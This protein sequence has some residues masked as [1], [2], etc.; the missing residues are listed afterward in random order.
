LYSWLFRRLMTRSPSC[1]SKLSGMS[2][3]SVSRGSRPPGHGQLI[4]GVA[5][6]LLDVPAIRG[7]LAALDRVQLRL[8]GLELRPRPGV[9]DFRG[10]DGVVH[11]RDRPVV[12]HLEEARPG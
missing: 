7:R 6:P 11:E 4:L 1:S 9:V 10:L 3:S 8:R 12:E 2:S 5:K